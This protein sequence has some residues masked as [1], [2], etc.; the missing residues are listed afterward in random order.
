ME[1][2]LYILYIL[3]VGWGGGVF[4]GL[5]MQLSLM[6]LPNVGRSIPE[7]LA[8]TGE[9]KLEA[10]LPL[11]EAQGT[12]SIGNRYINRY[13]NRWWNRWQYMEYT[14]NMMEIDGNTWWTA[15]NR[16]NR[17]QENFGI[18]VQNWR[19]EIEVHGLICEARELSK[20]MGE[21]LMLRQGLLFTTFRFCG[22]IDYLSDVI[23]SQVWCEFTHRYPWHPWHLLGWGVYWFDAEVLPLC[24]FV[25]DDFYHTCVHIYIYIMQQVHLRR[26]T[27]VVQYCALRFAVGCFCS[28]IHVFWLLESAGTIW[29]D[30]CGLSNLFGYCHLAFKSSEEVLHFKDSWHI[31]KSHISYRPTLSHTYP[32]LLSTGPLDVYLPNFEVD[33]VWYFL[34]LDLDLYLHPVFLE[35]NNPVLLALLD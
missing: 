10:G 30:L 5:V 17:W 32:T 21:L 11:K 18:W 26:K 35:H 14:W 20:Q 23:I 28:N 27:V 6:S 3:F 33:S 29:K 19:P 31:H 8:E 24:I 22:L 13:I 16:W 15:W 34:G 7:T 4:E 12:E 2:Y 25:V 1:L 9:V